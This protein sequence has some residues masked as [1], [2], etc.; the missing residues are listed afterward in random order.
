MP[1]RQWTEEE[2]KFC[3]L[4]LY[5]SQ[6]CAMDRKFGATKLNNILYFSDF[7]SYAYLGRPITGFEYQKLPNGPAPRKFLSVRDKMVKIGI[8][9]LQ[10]ILLSSGKIQKRTVNLRCPNLKVFSGEEIAIVDRVI[11]V[12]RDADA[13]TV[14]ELSHAKVGWIVANLKETIPYETVFLSGEPLSEEDIQR[15]LEVARE[16]DLV[17][18]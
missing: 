14:S 9:G 3:E 1:I 12:L 4:I 11:D 13:D 15:G 17:G 10:E 6:Q 16:Y 8:L 7:Q 2:D 5:I 18:A